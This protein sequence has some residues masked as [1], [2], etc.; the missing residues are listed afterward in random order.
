MKNQL[1]QYCLR[2]GDTC[3][4]LGHRLSEL[5]SKGPILEEDIALT[6]IALD[7]IGQAEAL[8]KYAGEVEGEGRTEDD[9]AYRRAERKFYNCL[10][11]EQPNSDFAYVIARQ[12]FLSAWFYQLYNALLESKDETLA[13]IAGKAKKE[14]TYH[15]RHS[16]E[17]MVR[18]GQ[19]TDESQE[20]IQNAVN[21]LW[22][23]TGELFETDELENVLSNEGVAV[24]SA[25]LLSGWESHVQT[26]FERAGL[27][28]PETVVMATGSKQGIHSEYLGHIL[29]DMQYLQRA[30]PEAAW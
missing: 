2:L 28:K 24:K 22:R 10:L 30:Y 9:L 3:L 1:F 27:Q 20:R 19:G 29:S 4:I 12:F 15:L 17:W 25:D 26:V 5:C 21:R 8:L 18:L 13:G 7:Y 14:V 23:F 6:N 11:S 16:G